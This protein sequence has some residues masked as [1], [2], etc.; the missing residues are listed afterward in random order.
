MKLPPLLVCLLLAGCLSIP[1]K[2]QTVTV[3]WHRTDNA[4]FYCNAKARKGKVLVGCQY[5]LWSADSGLVCHVV[6]PDGT[7][8]EILSVVGH[9]LKHCFDNDWHL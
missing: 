9:E 8:D 7:D 4:E 6:A 3:E 1:V 2:P 5:W